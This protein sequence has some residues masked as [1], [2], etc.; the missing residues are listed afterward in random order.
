MNAMI[1]KLDGLCK[2]LRL[3][4]L[5][6]VQLQTNLKDTMTPLEVLTTF[7][8]LQYQY[9]QNKS[10]AARIKMARFPRKKTLKE[11]DFSQQTGVTAEQMNRLC[12]FM[13][14]EQAFNVVFL[15]AP[16]LGKSHLATALGY[17]AAEAGYSVCFITLEGCKCQALFYRVR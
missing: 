8:E 16:G 7:L 17:A 3:E 1:E 6:V 5:S 2:G 10:T 11:Y 15:G 4:G 9:K 14:I 13:W 12:D